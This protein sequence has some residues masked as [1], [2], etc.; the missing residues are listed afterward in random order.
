ML[1]GVYQIVEHVLP[2]ILISKYSRQINQTYDIYTTSPINNYLHEMGVS[3][4]EQVPVNCDDGPYS[5]SAPCHRDSFSD[6]VHLDTASVIKWDRSSADLDNYLVEN[7]WQLNQGEVY[8]KLSQLFKNNSNR[9]EV[10]AVYHKGRN[11]VVCRLSATY[12]HRLSYGT[13]SVNEGCYKF[14]RSPSSWLRGL[15][16]YS[17]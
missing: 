4:T 6:M 5:P 15:K 2:G 3:F 11:G 8:S 9:S 7:G 13:V 10:Y 16:S 1:F 14:S 12:V 17:D